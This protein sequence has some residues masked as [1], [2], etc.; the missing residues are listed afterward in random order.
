MAKFLLHAKVQREIA[1]VGATGAFTASGALHSAGLA[2]LRH[3]LR[4]WAGD[5]ALHALDEVTV[6]SVKNVIRRVLARDHRVI[7]T[8]VPRAK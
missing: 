7:V 2:K 4:P 8:T 3:A 1:A 6:G 5:R